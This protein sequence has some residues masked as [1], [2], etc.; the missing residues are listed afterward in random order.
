[1][2]LAALK[3]NLLKASCCIV[4]VISG[5]PGR[6][7]ISLSEMLETINKSNSGR[8]RKVLK[9][10]RDFFEDDFDPEF[11]D[12]DNVF[13]TAGSGSPPLPDDLPDKLMDILKKN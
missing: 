1:M 4:L 9:P 6:R 13:F 2:V 8:E 3:F 5:G 12:R 10:Y 7:L 11:F